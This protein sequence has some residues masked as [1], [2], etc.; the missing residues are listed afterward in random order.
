MI[1]L[2]GIRHH[3]PGSA[4]AVLRALEASPPDCLLVEIP[5]DAEDLIKFLAGSKAEATEGEEPIIPHSSLL[6][7]PVAMLIYDPKDLSRASYLPF[8]SFSP[9]WVAIWFALERNIPVRFMDLPMELNFALDEM[10]KQNVQLAIPLPAGDEAPPPQVGDWVEVRRDPMAF[11]ANLAGYAD[12]ERWWEVTFESPDNDTDVFTA[13]LDMMTALREGSEESDR[14]LQREAHMRQTIRRAVKDGFEN[15]AVVCGAWH[16]PAL[17]GF[18]KIKV[19][20]DSALLKGIKKVKTAATWIPWSYDRLTFRSG[21]RSG[22]ISPA[23]YELLFHQK[24]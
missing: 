15:I 17:D 11:F 16:V 3:G 4:R 6:V 21:Y 12:S 9:E 1:H 10:E 24:K 23:W 7:P 14:T 19:S 5:A 18:E 2:Y 8:A 20:H 22:V 13:I